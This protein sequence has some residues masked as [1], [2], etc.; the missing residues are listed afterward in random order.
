MK[1]RTVVIS[2]LSVVVES[3]AASASFALV[4]RVGAVAHLLVTSVSVL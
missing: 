2:A 1:G 4:V 3:I